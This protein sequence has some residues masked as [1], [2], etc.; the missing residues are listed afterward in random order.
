MGHCVKYNG[1]D[2]KYIGDDFANYDYLLL[3]P[4][5]FTLRIIY[6]NVFCVNCVKLIHF[7]KNWKR[8]KNLNH[9]W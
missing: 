1:N 9:Q 6:Q 7:F 2:V 8:L 5:F 4:D 3:F